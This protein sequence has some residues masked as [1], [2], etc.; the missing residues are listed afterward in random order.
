[1]QCNCILIN[2][3]PVF[4]V[5]VC[6]PRELAC[7]RSAAGNNFEC[8][9]PIYRLVFRIN[10]LKFRMLIIINNNNNILLAK[11]YLILLI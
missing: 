11:Y 9:I 7:A 2:Y 8:E 6:G 10:V 5:P 1:M 4:K 3:P